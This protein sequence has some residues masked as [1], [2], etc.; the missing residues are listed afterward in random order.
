[1]DSLRAAGVQVH[2]AHPL[3]LK[4][5]THQRVTNDVRDAADVADLDLGELAGA[6]H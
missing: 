5:F 2:L 6:A 3:G 4:G 1:V